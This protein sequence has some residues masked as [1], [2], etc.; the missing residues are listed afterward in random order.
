M[1][2]HATTSDNKN[3]GRPVDPKHLEPIKISAKP[4]DVAEAIMQ[5]PPKPESEWRYLKDKSR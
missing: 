4:K 2:K 3:Q 1:A 5:K